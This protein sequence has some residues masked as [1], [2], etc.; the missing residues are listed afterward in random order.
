ML[1]LLSPYA[2]GC[3]LRSHDGRVQTAPVFQ[4]AAPLWS[5]DASP[6]HPRGLLICPFQRSLWIRVT[7]TA[8]WGGSALARVA[9][10]H[11]PALASPPAPLDGQRWPHSRWGWWFQGIQCGEH[12]GLRVCPPAWG[13]W[14]S[15]SRLPRAPAPPRGVLSGRPL[16][17]LRRL[18]C[19]QDSP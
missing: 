10:R 17:V 15:W 8:T 14:G 16:T 7:V 11:C 19:C 4:V 1:V 13:A 3:H 5:E 6:T 18:F 9:L 12:A 2:L